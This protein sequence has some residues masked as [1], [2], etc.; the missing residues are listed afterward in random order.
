MTTP[1][2]EVFYATKG[3]E[4]TEIESDERFLRLCALQAKERGV[5]TARHAQE[6]VLLA[7]AIRR[8]VES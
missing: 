8:E 1:N 5:L 4:L 3:V 6:R 7:L 2:Y